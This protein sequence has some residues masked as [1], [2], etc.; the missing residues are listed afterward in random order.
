MA[1]L[2]ERIKPNP[3]IIRLTEEIL[4]QNNKVLEM[5]ANLLAVLSN[6]CFIVQGQES[7]Q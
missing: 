5:N 7:E 4:K 2:L 3:D 1:E 6:P